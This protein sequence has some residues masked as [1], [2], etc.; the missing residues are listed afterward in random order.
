MTIAPFSIQQAPRNDDP[1]PRSRLS[2][3]LSSTSRMENNLV[4]H[5]SLHPSRISWINP[6]SC[7]NPLS[8]YASNLLNPSGKKRIVFNPAGS[9]GVRIPLPCGRCMGCRLAKSRDW[10]LRSQ[11]E[12]QMHEHSCFITLTYADEH[13]PRDQSLKKSDFQDFMKRLRIAHSDIPIRYVMCGEYGSENK[14]EH[15]HALIFGYHFPDRIPIHQGDPLNRM[16]TRSHASLG[17]QTESTE[18]TELWGHGLTHVGDVTFQSAA[19]VARYTTSKLN[20]PALDVLDAYTGLKHYERNHFDTGDVVDILPEYLQASL[21]P[22]IGATFY[23]KFKTSMYPSDQIYVGH[24]PDAAKKMRPVFVKPPKYYDK[25]LDRERPD[26]LEYVVEQ[27]KKFAA[28][29][30]DNFT[31]ERLMAKAKILECRMD[32][33]DLLVRNL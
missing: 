23:E 17:C 26:I 7:T 28:D 22:G 5:G 27:R 1:L 13:R 21:R 30:A 18:L 3:A 33:S 10:A 24:C 20:G 12:A 9:D 2:L 4:P 11:H 32:Y 16:L 15:Y 19:Y 6:M 25:L 29:H 31:D 8:G 14:R